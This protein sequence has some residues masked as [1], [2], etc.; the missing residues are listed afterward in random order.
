M[1]DSDNIHIALVM[2]KTKVAPI[3]RITIPRLELCGAH[4]LAQILHHVKEVFYLPLSS[5][6]AWTIVLNWLSGN[7]HRFKPYVGNRISYIMDLIQPNRWNHVR[8]TE[9][10]ADCPLRGILPSELMDHPLWWTGPDWLHFGDSGMIDIP[11]V[12]PRDPTPPHCSL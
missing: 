3:K 4:L 2:S 9:N 12:K 10:P 1:L 5:V 6:Y 11:P 7:S 8:G